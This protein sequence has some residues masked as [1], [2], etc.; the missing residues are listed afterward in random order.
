M[1]I[2]LLIASL[3]HKVMLQQA[4]TGPV[5]SRHGAVQGVYRQ[6][7]GTGRI[8]TFLGIPYAAPPVGERRFQ[9]AQ[10]PSN[11]AGPHRADKFGPACPQTGIQG[12]EESMQ[13]VQLQ[14]ED[15]LYLNIFSPGNNKLRIKIL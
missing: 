10:P 12:V 9:H 7:P 1:F 11:W 2:L 6:L 5:W 4:M 13:F 14:S 8:A 15:C 3:F